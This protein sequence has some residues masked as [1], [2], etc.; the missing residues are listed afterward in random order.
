VI[1][2]IG[3]EH[4]SRAMTGFRCFLRSLDSA[5]PLGMHVGL[6]LL[7]RNNEILGEA[8]TDSD[9][10][11]TFQPGLIRGQAGLA[12]AALLAEGPMAISC[13]LTSPAAA[14]TCRIGAL[15]DAPSAGVDV[16]AWTERGIYR[17][18]E[19][20][21]PQALARDRTAN[22]MADLPLTLVIHSVRTVLRTGA[23]FPTA[24]PWGGHALALALP[25]NAMQGAWRAALH[26]DPKRP[27]VAE[28]TFLVEDF[29]P[30][31]IE[32]ELDAGDAIVSPPGAEKV[33]G[34]YLYGAPAE[35]L[36]TEVKS[37]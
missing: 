37:S 7:A 2:D 16:M 3:D 28:V 36:S 6:T 20:V 24:R 22:A 8:V 35:G 15:P 10:R 14:L 27:A 19:T 31:R 33:A 21:H 17:G 23:L 26:M 1:S 30:D 9:G 11:A 29:Q 13:F 34:R 4:L 18:G 5:K 32:I 25:E 12:P